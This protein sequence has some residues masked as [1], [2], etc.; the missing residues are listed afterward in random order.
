LLKFIESK[1][2]VV[3]V[4]EGGQRKAM[5]VYPFTAIREIA[6]NALIHQ[7]FSISGA[8]PIIEVYDDRIETT[9]PGRL[10]VEV[11]RII[12]DRKSRNEK[13]SK[14]MRDLGFCEE[15]G[16]GL[17]KALIEIEERFLPAPEFFPSP[18][19]MRVVLFGPKDF[20]SL[21]KAD[22]I[23]A[24]FCH[25]V[26]KWLKHDPMNNASLRA[27]FSLEEDDYQIASGI[28]AD[29]KRLNRIRPADPN[30][31]TKNARYVPYWV[32]QA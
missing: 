28:I 2:P 23:W 20:R 14:V 10:L 26:I 6:A 8:G 15:R 3:E 32:D 12:A 11:D 13:L 4:Y 7:D 31:G 30:Q 16:G 5:S 1:V 21:S 19:N 17:D 18:T 27:R 9:N 24:C 29:A 25:C 22:K